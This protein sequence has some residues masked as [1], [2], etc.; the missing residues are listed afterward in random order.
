[1]IMGDFNLDLM[2]NDN[3]AATNVFVNNLLS[4]SFLPTI[5][6]PTRISDNSATLI[7]NIFINKTKFTF[8]SSIIYND[9]SDHLPIAIHLENTL[10]TRKLAQP[11]KTRSFDFNSIEEFNLA[12]EASDW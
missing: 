4:H 9:I 3:H 7:D 2:K 11:I 5:H 8:E 1:M 6:N 10:I 12:L